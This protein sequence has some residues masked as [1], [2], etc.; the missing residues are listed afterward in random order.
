RWNPT[1]EKCKVYVGMV[2]CNYDEPGITRAAV[3]I[4]QIIMTGS[5][6]AEID[7]AD[8]VPVHWFLEA[9]K[10]LRD[11]G[12][13]DIQFSAPVS[14]QNWAE[15]S[16]AVDSVAKL[17]GRDGT[18]PDVEIRCLLSKDAPFKHVAGLMLLCSHLGIG[19]LRLGIHPKKMVKATLPLDLGLVERVK[20]VPD[21]GGGGPG[22]VGIGGGAGGVLGGALR[23]AEESPRLWRRPPHR[24][25][26]PHGAHLV[27]EPSGSGRNLVLQEVHDEL[28]EGDMHGPGE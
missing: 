12:L 9:L 4:R 19:N 15:L 28:P 3:K 25:R 6:R 2:L 7:A 16:N 13:E 17:A 22:I 24:I 23:G 5:N 27:E 20:K 1:I 18:L 8:D 26:R 11:N 10:M 14:L 21:P